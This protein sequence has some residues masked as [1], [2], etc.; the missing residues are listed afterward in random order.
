MHTT[1]YN[2]FAFGLV[3]TVALAAG[4]TH[5]QEQRELRASI[6]TLEPVVIN[7]QRVARAD[8][9]RLPTVVVTGRRTRAA[10]GVQVAAARTVPV[11]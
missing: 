8:V 7:V 4:L 10:D 6:V 9:Q 1:S 3:A 2:A 11:L 5:A